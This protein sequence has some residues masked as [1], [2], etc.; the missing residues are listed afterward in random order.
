VNQT[1]QQDKSKNGK[2]KIHIT[3][4]LKLLK[5][6]IILLAFKSSK[7]NFF[8]LLNFDQNST[9]AVIIFLSHYSLLN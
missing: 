1:N 5:E 3:S 9:V 6:L 8:N 2:L 4:L 7:S